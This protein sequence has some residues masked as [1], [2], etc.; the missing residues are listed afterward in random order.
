[1]VDSYNDFVSVDGVVHL[2]T[3]LGIFFDVQGR[4]IFVPGHC[5]EPMFRRFRQGEIVTLRVLR[6][7]AETESLAG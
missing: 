7:F 1:L 3:D 2:F 4:R 6:S 5:M